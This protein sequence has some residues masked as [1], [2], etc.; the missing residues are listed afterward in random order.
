MLRL[1]QT[2]QLHND[3]VMSWVTIQ[4]LDD[5]LNVVDQSKTAAYKRDTHML[6]Q[7]LQPAPVAGAR[8][9]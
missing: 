4:C 3:V 2:A 1:T 5:D 6:P 8:A 7:P 9:V